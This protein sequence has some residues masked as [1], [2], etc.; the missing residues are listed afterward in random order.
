ME[1]GCMY[2]PD[3]MK[4]AGDKAI[5]FVSEKYQKEFTPITYELSDYLSDT[6]IIH[7]YTDGMDPENEHVEIYLDEKGLSTDYHDN[8]FSFHVRPEAETYIASIVGKE[9]SDIKVFRSNEYEASPD[10]LT[11]EHS[12]ADLYIAQ[13][14]Y[15]MD[16]KVYINADPSM[17]ET[18][19][20][21]KIARIENELIETGHRYSLYIFALSN[22]AF[23]DIDRFTQDDFWVFYAK[24]PQPDCKMYYYAYNVNI[25]DGGIL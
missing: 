14:D 21:E 23:S 17:T 22:T 18:E 11:S 15:W 16:V 9:F 19:Y 2:N 3:T 4:N 5:R 24:N 20:A 25:F 6:D 7:C 10:E 8:Y 12:L 13:P 1:V